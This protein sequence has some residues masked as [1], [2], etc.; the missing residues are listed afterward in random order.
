MALFLKLGQIV[1]RRDF[2]TRVVRVSASDDHVKGF[3]VYV[4]DES[5]N[6]VKIRDDQGIRDT[7]GFLQDPKTA[8]LRALNTTSVYD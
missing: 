1:V 6:P 3:D 8:C 5:L 4:C 7:L 2:I